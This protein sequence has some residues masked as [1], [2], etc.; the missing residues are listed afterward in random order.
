MLFPST[1]CKKIFEDD[2][3]IL[4]NIIMGKQQPLEHLLFYVN[5]IYT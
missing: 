3:R 4:K 1:S 5:K 2:K